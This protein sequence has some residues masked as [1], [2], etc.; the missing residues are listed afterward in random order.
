MMNF[1]NFN[2][3]HTHITKTYQLTAVRMVI[4]KNAPKNKC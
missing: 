3:M 1:R 4:R 2:D